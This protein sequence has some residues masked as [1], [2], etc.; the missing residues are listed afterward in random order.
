VTDEQR[1]TTAT[2]QEEIDSRSSGRVQQGSL[3][4]QFQK[5][6]SRI[7]PSRT[8][9]L[10]RGTTTTKQSKGTEGLGTSSSGEYDRNRSPS[11]PEETH[12]F[13]ASA[14][15]AR[16]AAE[17]GDDDCCCGA[18]ETT[19]SRTSERA[20]RGRNE[21]VGQASSPQEKAHPR[22]PA[23]AAS[24]RRLRQRGSGPLDWVR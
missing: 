4:N 9:P 1:Q 15:S 5:P 16:R 22:G 11:E 23:I 10:A 14:T 2:D 19:R 17:L 21:F 8:C 12:P 18:V 24:K 6:P 3:R 20:R 7:S 13:S